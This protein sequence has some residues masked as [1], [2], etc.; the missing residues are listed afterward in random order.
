M[1]FLAYHVFTEHHNARISPN[2]KEVFIMISFKDK[3][4]FVAG[5]STGIVATAQ[6]L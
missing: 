5:G 1:L 3:V 6:I 4:I 2:L